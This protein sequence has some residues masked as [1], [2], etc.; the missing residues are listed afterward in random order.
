MIEFRGLLTYRYEQ[1]HDHFPSYKSAVLSTVEYC[2]TGLGVGTCIRSSGFG[3]I[4]NE[5][6]TSAGRALLLVTVCKFVDSSACL[7]LSTLNDE[8]V[9][10]IS[11]ISP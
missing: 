10:V 4:R 5:D 8:N 7:I 9:T 11:S 3:L 2:F 6:A 1:A